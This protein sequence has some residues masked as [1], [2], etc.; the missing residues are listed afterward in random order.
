MEAPQN[1]IWNY[2]HA[3][4]PSYE[5][6]EEVSTLVLSS[7]CLAMGKP[8]DLV[9]QHLVQGDGLVLSVRFNIA[10]AVPLAIY[11]EAKLSTVTEDKTIDRRI[12]ICFFAQ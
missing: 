11:C 12:F 2:S 6:L 5:Q 9:E 10:E 8:V 3:Q 4:R 1:T 7:F